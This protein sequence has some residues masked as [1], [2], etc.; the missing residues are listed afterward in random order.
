MLR[1]GQPNRKTTGR[2][3]EG[4]HQKRSDFWSH[5]RNTFAEKCGSPVSRMA[6]ASE[7][8]VPVL[9]P[10]N[11][12][13]FYYC[14]AVSE[15]RAARCIVATGA[16]L[17]RGLLPRDVE[18]LHPRGCMEVPS[19]CASCKICCQGQITQ[20]RMPDLGQTDSDVIR[21]EDQ[22]V[23]RLDPGAWQEDAV[24]ALSGFRHWACAC[25]GACG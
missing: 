22:E 10:G 14:E 18:P 25:A 24:A 4:G 17:E 13:M 9:D 21:Y 2:V 19:S 8:E 5:V 15:Q 20:R 7:E 16:L 12:G 11:V 6:M 1:F 3:E 23:R